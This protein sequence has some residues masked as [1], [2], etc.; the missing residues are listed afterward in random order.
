MTMVDWKGVG[1]IEFPEDMSQEDINQR[2]SDQEF[3]F[4]EQFGIPSDP[5]FWAEIMPD[6]VERGFR[7]TVMGIQ[8][9]RSSPCRGGR[10][11]ILGFFSEG[12]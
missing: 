11:A 6:A 10:G 7:K 9:A 5:G 2:L 12:L 4:D 1:L 8:A 3:Y